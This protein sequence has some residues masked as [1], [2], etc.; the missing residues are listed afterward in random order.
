M[1]FSDQRK[2]KLDVPSTNSAGQVFTIND[3]IHHLCENMLSPKDKTDVFV[4]DGT[5]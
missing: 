4:L 2:H 1:L 5:V 3:L